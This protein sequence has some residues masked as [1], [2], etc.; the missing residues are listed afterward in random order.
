MTERALEDVRILDLSWQV[1]GPYC[2]KLLADYGAEVIKVERPGTGDPARELGPFP[3]DVPNPEKS[4]LF[5][6]LNTNKSG[7]TLDLASEAGQKI[8]WELVKDVDILV[9][10]FSPGVMA[11]LGLDFETLSK[12]NPRLVM[13]SISNFGQTG[14]YRDFKATDMIEYALGGAMFSTGTVDREPLKLYENTIQFQAG[15]LSAVASMTALFGAEA[16][17]R[18]EQLDISI[19]ETQAAGIDR[20]NTFRIVYQYTGDVNQR[21]ETTPGFATGAFP[22]K[23]G[24][25]TIMGGTIF[26]PKTVVMLDMPELLTHPDYSN[27]FRQADP[28]VAEEFLTILL[29]WLMDR[30]KLEVWE[31][32]Q[33]AKVISS[34]INTTEDLLRDPHFKERG[35]WVDV[36]HPEAGT[37]KQTGAPFKMA[38]TPWAIVKPAPTLG[39]HN[40][41]VLGKLGYGQSDLENFKSSGII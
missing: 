29:P 2:T 15:T 30:T 37:V 38:E 20:T 28:E 9:E 24:Y 25:V 4:G 3:D 32:A 5:L 19:M 11:K 1:S 13:T 7:I 40:Q 23:D 10:S 21:L 17:G 27:M 35:F 18:G 41:E 14:P 33:K 12:I 16:R 31:E 36:V 22:C 34:P 6:H 26:F 8:I 39:Q